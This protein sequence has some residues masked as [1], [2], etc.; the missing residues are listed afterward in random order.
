M[1]LVFGPN[2]ERICL[3]N[4]SHFTHGCVNGQITPWTPF[5]LLRLLVL[6]FLCFGI[7]TNACAPSIISDDIGMLN[8]RFMKPQGRSVFL[9]NL[10][11][12]PEE[13]I[14]DYVSNFVLDVPECLGLFVLVT[15]VSLLDFL[16]QYA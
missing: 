7:R 12:M 5:S 14:S 9:E 13:L 1:F 16:V 6:T 11:V 8:G 10:D 3:H 4:E 2:E 15:W